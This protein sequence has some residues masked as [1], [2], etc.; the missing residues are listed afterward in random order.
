MFNTFNSS[1]DAY[2][3]AN[4]LSEK[5]GFIAHVGERKETSYGPL[6]NLILFCFLCYK[7]H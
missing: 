4:I 2:P 6:E 3:V 7:E 5:C 1:L